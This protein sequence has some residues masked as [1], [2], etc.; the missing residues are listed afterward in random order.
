[1]K[2]LVKKTSA[3]TIAAYWGCKCKTKYCKGYYPFTKTAQLAAATKSTR[4]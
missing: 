4:F 2:K 3:K 1:M